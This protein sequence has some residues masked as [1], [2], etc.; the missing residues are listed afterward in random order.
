M[1][2]P[3]RHNRLMPKKWFFKEFAA[4]ITIEIFGVGFFVRCGATSS[5]EYYIFPLERRRRFGIIR[6]VGAGQVSGGKPTAN[7]NNFNPS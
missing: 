6:A 5:Q 4:V 3:A 1:L 7:F 2:L